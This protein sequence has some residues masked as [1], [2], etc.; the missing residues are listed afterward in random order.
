MQQP[1]PENQYP[2][3]HTSAE[4]TCV[5]FDHTGVKIPEK[6]LF[7]REKSGTVTYLTANDNIYFTNRTEGKYFGNFSE[8][9]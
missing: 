7:V 4:V 9:C 6:I 2:L 8:Y 3:E 5:A 1:W